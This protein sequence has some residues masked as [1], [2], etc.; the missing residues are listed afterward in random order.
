MAIEE[1]H[2]GS[3]RGVSDDNAGADSEPQRLAAARRVG[4][5]AAAARHA[6]DELG[7][8]FPQSARYMHD[9]AAG[10]EHLSNLLRD[11]H[12]DDLR[13]LFGN[14]GRYRPVAFVAGVALI[15]LGLSWFLKNSNG[16]SPGPATGDAAVSE[17]AGRH[18][19]D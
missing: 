12:L 2:E 6:A 1:L 19:T 4:S 7:E 3:N 14:L 13:M 9:T 5:L 15:G 10:F 18:E 16:L 17:N 8:E 11:P